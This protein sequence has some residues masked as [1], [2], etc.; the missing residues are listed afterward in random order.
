[1]IVLLIRLDTVSEQGPEVGGAGAEAAGFKGREVE[2]GEVQDEALAADQF[3][4]ARLLARPN[5]LEAVSRIRSWRFALLLSEAQ[6]QRSR[7]N[8]SGK[9]SLISFAGRRDGNL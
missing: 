9:Q 6:L 4:L 2:E 5:N 7:F 1:M 8:G 3:D